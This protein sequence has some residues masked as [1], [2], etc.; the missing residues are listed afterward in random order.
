VKLTPDDKIWRARL[1]WLG[2]KNV[3]LPVQLPYGQWLLFALLFSALTGAFWLLFHSVVFVGTGFAI[4]L[5]LTSWI[6]DRVDADRPARKVI[7]TALT[8]WHADPDD[9]DGDLPPLTAGH[10][11]VGGDR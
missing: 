11:T 10:I 1:V 6:W 3:T 8:D 2:W 5:F 9:E 4:A 7:R